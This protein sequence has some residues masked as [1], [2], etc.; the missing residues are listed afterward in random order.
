MYN[1][2][3]CII[4]Y[5]IYTYILSGKVL[6]VLF[7]WSETGYNNNINNMYERK[8]NRTFSRG[9]EQSSTLLPLSSLYFI[10]IY[11]YCCDGG[12]SF[13]FHCFSSR[14]NVPNTVIKRPPPCPP[15]RC[16]CTENP[17]LADAPGNQ[18]SLCVYITIIIILIFKNFLFLFSL[19]RSIARV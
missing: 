9:G 10:Y 7:Y 14:M 13:P 11:L 2:I 1:T 19:S 4:Y 17:A 16:R 8:F 18:S 12:N 5:Y 6:V 15:K 3:V